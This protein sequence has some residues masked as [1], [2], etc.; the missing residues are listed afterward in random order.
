MLLFSHSHM[1]TLD[2]INKTSSLGWR[3]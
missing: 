2:S 3:V 1:L